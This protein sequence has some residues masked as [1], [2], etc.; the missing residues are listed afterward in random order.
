MPD[1]YYFERGDH[2]LDPPFG[3]DIETC[4]TYFF[5]ELGKESADLYN[6][7]LNEYDNSCGE[8]LVGLG[9]VDRDY[10]PKSTEAGMV[11]FVNSVFLNSSR[12]DIKDAIDAYQWIKVGKSCF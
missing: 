1:P 10:G 4:F 9:R 11:E 12:T 7:I 3:S 6:G 2:R 5:G 8:A